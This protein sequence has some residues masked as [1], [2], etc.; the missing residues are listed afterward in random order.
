MQAIQ[1]EAYAGPGSLQLVELDR[2]R[3]AVGEVLIEVQASGI[4]FAELELTWGRY[5]IP[6]APPFIMGFEAAG[7]VAEV[8]PGVKN[9]QIG[10]RVTSIVSS[11]G[12][13][14]YA[15]APGAAVIP[16]PVGISFEEATTIPIQGVTAYSLLSSAAELR[17]GETVLIQSGAGGVGLYL[18]QLAKI[19]GAGKVIALAGTPEKVELLR[20][21]GAD[22]VLNHEQGDWPEKVLEAT[23]GKGVD[24][25]LESAAGEIG[26]KSVG[27][28]AP[29]G[30]IVVFGAKNVHEALPAELVRQMIYKNQTVTG[31]NLPSRP[32]E[33]LVTAV[34]LLLEWIVAKKIRIFA[35]QRYAFADVRHAFEMLATRKS[36]GK[37]VL[38]PTESDIGEHRGR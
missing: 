38:V 18:V 22:I 21:L 9:V 10:D 1:L 8:G 17:V 3:P 14:D 11:G 24:V 27:L 13:A 30:R 28:C 23:Q 29:L 5:T 19:L 33:K 36:I 16:I 25:V 20:D 34:P 15:V 2:P 6:K 26:K 4:N 31:F 32:Q 37:V 35:D 7:I 12:F